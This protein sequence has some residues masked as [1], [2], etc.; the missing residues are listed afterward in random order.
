MKT[1]ARPSKNRRRKDQR[2]AYHAAINALSS[3]PENPDAIEALT[4]LVARYC[5]QVDQQIDSIG[6]FAEELCGEDELHFINGLIHQLE[7]NG[8]VTIHTRHGDIQIKADINDYIRQRRSTGSRHGS[9]HSMVAE[10]LHER[11]I[12]RIRPH[13]V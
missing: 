12:Q 9:I 5:R 4:A 1:Q 11:A 7:N 6:A 3:D 2:G 13:H 8:W 10:S